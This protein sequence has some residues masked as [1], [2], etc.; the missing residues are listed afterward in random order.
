MALTPHQTIL[1]TFASFGAVVGIH[2]GSMPV[3]VQQSGISNFDFG[4]AGGIGMMANIT[5]MS[6]GG[7]INR[8]ADHRSVLLIIL[9]LVV[10]ALG[11]ALLV[12]SIATFMLSF[13]LLSFCLGM[14]DL[15]MNAEAS[16]VE[17]ELGRKVFSSYHGTASLGIAAF[18]IAGSLISVTLA[19]WFGLLAVLV[20]TALAWSAIQKSI[21][22]R[23]LHGEDQHAPPV[24]LP[25]RI[26]TFIGL[27][28]GAN[29]ACEGTAILWAGQLLTAIAPDLAAISGFGVAFYGLCGGLMRLLGDRLRETF[30]DLRVMS[31]SLTT[32]VAGFVV[33]GLAPGFWMSVFAF[34]AVG[35]G[36]AIVFPCLFALAA[37]IVPQGRAAAMGFVAAVGGLPRVA[38]P[39]ILGVVASQGGVSAV[40]GASAF[41][42]LIALVIIVFSFAQAARLAPANTV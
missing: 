13:I 40:F 39:W 24:V 25:R 14:M 26:L 42:A 5:A 16:I 3:L 41:V 19:P 37:N 6:L 7:R 28:A 36:L 15:F 9:P 22:V 31:V 29:V 11:F 21:P 12:N 8:M 32:A 27:A 38:L 17:Q 34:A 23:A 18:A 33:L 20:P 35:F 1:L 10:A 2:V 30:G 4:V